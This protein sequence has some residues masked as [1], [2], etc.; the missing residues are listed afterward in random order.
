MVD[1]R[2]EG[3][4]EPPK[5]R[6]SLGEHKK[7]K[8]DHPKLAFKLNTLHQAWIEK[9]FVGKNANAH[10]NSLQD[11][12]PTH[13][14]KNAIQV[15]LHNFMVDLDFVFEL[16]PTL[17]CV[18]NIVVVHG[19]GRPKQ[20]AP[21][22]RHPQQFLLLQP[23]CERF[24]THHSKM[25]VVECPHELRVSVV[26]ANFVF[27]DWYNKTNGIWTGI[28]PRRAS[29]GSD[30]SRGGFH[31]DL[32]DY[33]AAMRK[34]GMNPPTNWEPNNEQDA[35][36]RLDLKFLDEFD[37]S[38]ATARL[39]GSIPGRHNGAAL[40]KWGHMRVREILDGESPGAKFSHLLFQF[41]SLSS[42]GEKAWFD[43]L[44]RSFGGRKWSSQKIQVVFPTQTEILQSLE[45]WYAGKSLP[46]DV[47]N[48]DKLRKKLEELG[49]EIC[50]WDGGDT[51]C[52]GANGR[53]RAVP[54]I[55]TFLRYCMEDRSIP[56]FILAS[57]NLSQAAWGKL[58][59]KDTQLYIKSYEVGVLLLP[60]LVA[61]QDPPTIRRQSFY[62]PRLRS[63]APSDAWI[64]PVP[65]A[66]PPRVYKPDDII[67]STTDGI[68]L[69]ASQRDAPRDRYHSKAGDPASF[70]LEQ[71]IGRILVQKIK[72]A[73]ISAGEDAGSLSVN[74]SRVELPAEE[75]IDLC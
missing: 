69:P 8:T 33:Y 67:W 55:K 36:R 56:W 28:F 13:I 6:S 51:E 48:A 73:P 40:G 26:T 34:C 31:A 68:Q 65:Y 18:P 49:G 2:V 44:C 37:F 19:D 12:L 66:L 30:S 38:S 41:S 11:L 50:G 52:G 24:G 39:I 1:S 62:A 15:H 23:P 27:S 46:C 42:V 64:L 22:I 72:E 43:E 4:G 45:G 32:Y 63:T 14:V 5:A 9:H 29:N 3:G 25:I 17:N 59:K 20:S 58:E 7:Q 71:A 21:Y 53:S 61:Q 75:V 60:S 16:C 47:K 70:Y 57:H 74:G 54:H 10:T 35:W